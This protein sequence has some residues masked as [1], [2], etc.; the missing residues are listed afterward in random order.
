[1]S[2]FRW[3]L[4]KL[5]DVAAQREAVLRQEMFRLA[6]ELARARQEQMW[7]R[8]RRRALLDGLLQGDSGQRLAQ[9]QL[10]V[11]CA[12]AARRQM[13]RLDA[14]LDRLAAQR[15]ERRTELLA[16][17]A[18]RE[19]LERMRADARQAH[20]REE[21]RREQIRLDDGANT[22]FARKVIGARTSVTAGE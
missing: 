15:A 3:R 8:A 2:R 19:A 17:K 16:A 10:V 5:L 12:G 21:S 6:R 1:M 20:E 14:A 9:Q 7:L 13:A 11:R 4:Q 22:R 18:S